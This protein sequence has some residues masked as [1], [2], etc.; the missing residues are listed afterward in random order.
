MVCSFSRPRMASSSISVLPSPSSVVY[1]SDTSIGYI[2]TIYRTDTTVNQATPQAWDGSGGG[3]GGGGLAPRP[4]DG[5]GG[6]HQQRAGQPEN[7]AEAPEQG[8]A[9]DHG[10]GADDGGGHRPG[11][12]RQAVEPLVPPPHVAGG[13]VG[14]V[15]VPPRRPD[16]LPDAPP[17]DRGHERGER[18]GHRGQAEAQ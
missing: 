16:H 9:G 12:P 6:Q 13:A 18:V 3:V 7:A 17:R 8:G 2:E 5:T 4:P 1:R 14:H 10:P 11:G 15:R